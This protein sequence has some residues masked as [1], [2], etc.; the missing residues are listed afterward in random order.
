MFRRRLSADWKL[1]TTR[2]FALHL[3]L[4]VVIKGIQ[5]YQKEQDLHTVLIVCFNSQQVNFTV[6]ADTADA[7]EM[8]IC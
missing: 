1:D 3:I 6:L 4:C 7:V 8:V 5:K 2:S